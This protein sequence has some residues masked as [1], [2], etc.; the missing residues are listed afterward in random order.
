MLALKIRTEQASDIFDIDKVTELAFHGMPYSGGD[1]SEI[2]ARLRQASA[3]SCSLVAVD[4]D[5]LLG[6]VAFSPA[7]LGSDDEHWFAL[8][9]V[10]VMPKSQGCGIGSKLIEAG[11]GQLQ[12]QG[13]LGCILVGNPDYY[14]RFGFVL[15]PENCAKD[16][17][18]EYFMMKQFKPSEV[19]GRF[20]F[21]RAFY[22]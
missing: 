8:G 2:I 22:G 12:S 16:E 1:E 6:H 20:S 19:S 17:P 11:L 10:S 7:T 4:G 13:A 21:H 14:R 18:P 9:P 15:S 3:L 5:Q